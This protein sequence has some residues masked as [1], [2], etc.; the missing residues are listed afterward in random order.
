MCFPK[1][2]KQLQQIIRPGRW[3]GGGLWEPLICSQVGQKLQ[4]T[5]V[6]HLKWVTV[7]WE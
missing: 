2:C 6:S 7:L 3:E 5:C 1:F 4:I